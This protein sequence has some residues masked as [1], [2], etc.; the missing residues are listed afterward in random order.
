[1]NSIGFVERNMLRNLRR[2][3]LTTLTVALATFIF[4]VLVSVP[5]SMDRIISDASTTLRLVVNNRT[6]PW[7]GVPA[8]DCQQIREMPGC[9]ACAAITGWFATYHED[10]DEIFGAAVSPEFSQVFTDY[11]ISHDTQAAMIKDRRAAVVGGV[12]MKKYGWKIGQQIMLKAN[13]ASN[14]ELTFII[15]GEIPSKHYPNSFVFRRDYLREAQK[16]AGMPD[17][18]VAWQLIVRADR[19]EH[20]APLAKEIDDA[21]RNSD[22]ETRSITES[23]A[24][25]GALS[26]IGN[27][28]GIVYGLCAVIA[29]TILL[30]AANAMAMMVRERLTDVAV[31]RTLG[32]SQARVATL[33]FGECAAIGLVAGALGAL[34]AWWLFSGGLTLGAALG[35]NGALWVTGASALEALAIA[36][37]LSLLSGVIPILNAIRIPPADAMRQVV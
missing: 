18:D 30:I 11:D 26:A 6:G 22:Y 34:P 21:Y 36:V 14:L 25:S 27:I 3:I 1:M 32:F 9:I 28:R 13:D 8:R 23:D 15:T 7:Y 31:M 16:A 29:L 20:V 12:L 17:N 35:G 10:R 5:T 2:T 4:A 24:L 33:L 19:A 37:I